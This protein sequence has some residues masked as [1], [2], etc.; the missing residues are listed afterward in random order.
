MNDLAKQRPAR[1]SNCCGELQA[2][3]HLKTVPT[4]G[5]GTPASCAL[6]WTNQHP[7]SCSRT[8]G[9]K[10]FETI[11]AVM[12]R[13]DYWFRRAGAPAKDAGIGQPQAARPHWQRRED[14]R[15]I[16]PS[17]GEGRPS[18]RQRTTCTPERPRWPLTPATPLLSLLQ[19][20]DH[21]VE[22]ALVP[23]IA[24]CAR[25]SE[26]GA[27]TPARRAPTGM[28][29][30]CGRVRVCCSTIRSSAAGAAGRSS[31]TEDCNNRDRGETSC[32][33]AGSR[34]SSFGHGRPVLLI[35]WEVHVGNTVGTARG[36]AGVGPLVGSTARRGWRRFDAPASWW[37]VGL[38]SD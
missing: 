22:L 35:A 2:H 11:D 24:S 32:D 31:D 17:V 38:S 6:A 16:S 21:A 1:R 19:V 18:G 27:P 33:L 26:C 29:R 13:A 10:R 4:D 23:A 5:G 12:S 3:E 37:P 15:R 34:W 20:G 36:I 9:S 7:S 30:R 25:H 28:S 14:G 8:D